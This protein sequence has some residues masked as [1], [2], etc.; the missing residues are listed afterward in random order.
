M[1]YLVHVLKLINI[2]I[3][4]LYVYTS[5]MLGLVFL[6][7]FRSLAEK[8]VVQVD[9]SNNLNIKTLGTWIVLWIYLIQFLH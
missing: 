4:K 3:L 2:V 8:N 5:F 6:F 9:C 7:S 1:R